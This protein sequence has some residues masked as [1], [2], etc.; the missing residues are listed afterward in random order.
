MIKTRKNILLAAFAAILFLYVG[1]WLLENVVEAPLEKRRGRTDRLQKDIEKRKLQLV[2]ARKAAKELAVW[3]AQ[4]LPSDT[5]VARSLYQAWMLELVGHV[6]LA[7]PHVDSGNP[8]SRKGMYHAL[9]FSVRGRGT[10]EQLTLLLFEFYRADHLH[11]IRSLRITPLERTDQLDLSISIEALVLPGADREDRLSP[12][13]SDRLASPELADYEMIV[14]RNLFG[15]GDGFDPTDHTYLT[16]VTYSDGQPE[17]WFTMRVDDT[18]LK[19]RKGQ[20]LRV[21]HFNGTVAEIA[22]VDVILES[23]GERWL[24]TIGENLTQASALPPEY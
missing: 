5:E 19:L 7:N 17:A 20:I 16:A 4:S 15:S 22:E 11:Q 9:S 2:R 14:R 8:T 24:L 21:G 12:A 13:T 18:V 3:E 10:L 1:N 6:K 23:E